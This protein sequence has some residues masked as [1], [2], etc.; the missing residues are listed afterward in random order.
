MR[1]HRSLLT[2][3]VAAATSIAVIAGSAPAEAQVTVT[4]PVPQ[5]PAG[6]IF[7]KG[8]AWRAD[9]TKAPVADNSPAMVANLTTQVAQYYGGV[10]AFNAG[11]FGTSV[12]TVPATQPRVDVQWNNCQNKSYTPPGLL[13]REGS[14]PRCRYQLTQSPPT[15]ATPR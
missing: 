9:V 13:A 2:L 4:A 15:A 3:T 8:T 12:Y 7:T 11:S 10:A 5:M 6:G 14:S 1:R